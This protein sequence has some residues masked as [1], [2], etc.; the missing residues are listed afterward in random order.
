MLFNIL[1]RIFYNSVNKGTR[2]KALIRFFKWQLF[3]KPLGRSLT[4]KY[5]S[6]SKLI[7]DKKF[8]ALTGTYY[9]GLFE[10]EIMAFA[11]KFL[12]KEDLFVDVGANAGTFTLIG[13]NE[14]GC[15]TIAFEPNDEAFTML[16]KNLKLNNNIVEVYNHC[17][18]SKKGLV[19]FT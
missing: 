16:K 18:G 10:F 17:L 8:T 7:I 11:L 19:Q 14:I 4:I 3:Y 12:R 15:K 1:I 6:K 5:L 2:L 13:S 9:N